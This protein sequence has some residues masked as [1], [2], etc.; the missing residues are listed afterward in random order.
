MTECVVAPSALETWIRRL[1]C[2]LESSDVDRRPAPVAGS[3]SSPM[4]PNSLIV[5]AYLSR[6]ARLWLAIRVTL[7]GVLL[8]AGANPIQL[9]AAAVVEIVFLSVVVS[10]LE[11][12]RRRE[13]ALLA[14]LGV[15]PLLLGALFAGPALIGEVALQLAGAALQ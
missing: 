1:A 6:G 14:N 15:R 3:P 12:Q 9:S 10:L 5:R 7:S 8:L 13:R 4:R 2:R 11:T